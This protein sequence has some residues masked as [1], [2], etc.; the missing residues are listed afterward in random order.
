MSAYLE[1][2]YVGDQ[3][4]G[5]ETGLGAMGKTDQ[6]AHDEFARLQQHQV[7]TKIAPYILDLHSDN[8]EIIN[9]IGISTDLFETL[10]GKQHQNWFEVAA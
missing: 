6:W 5:V 1:I 3:P 7:D 2:I 10:T 9:S 8:D 4:H